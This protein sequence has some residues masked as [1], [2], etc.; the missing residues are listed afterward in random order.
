MET[1]RYP[2]VIV[3]TEG[4][5]ARV[6]LNRPDRRNSIAGSM[7]KDLNAALERVAGDAAIRVVVLTGAGRDFCPGADLDVTA[8]NGDAGD[9]SSDRIGEDDFRM[10]RLLHEMP[11]VTIAAVNGACAGA[12]LGWAAAC[13]MRVAARSA[14]FNT[15]FL[16]V[17]VAGDMGGPWTLSR[18]VGPSKMREL[19]LLPGKFDAAEAERIGL[20]SR[21]WPDESFADE[22]KALAER[23]AGAAPLAL[24][25]LKANFLTAERAGLADYLA[26]ESQRHMAL[27]RTEDTNEAFKAIVEKRK[28]RFVGR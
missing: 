2:T 25:T 3:E 23:L 18:I 24:R 5:I 4:A 15:A 12:G 17:G 14:R 13:D 21:V 28:P 22:V 9:S 19:C 20:V 27:F 26:I 11:A 1:H 7:L 16:D 6:V 10:A 8:G